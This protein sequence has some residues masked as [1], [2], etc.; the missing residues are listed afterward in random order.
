MMS[1]FAER[2]KH[3]RESR[4]I[5]REEFAK[6]F[7]LAVNT[8]AMYETSR[9]EPNLEKLNQFATFFSVSLDYL[10]GRTDDPVK[11]YKPITRE[12]LEL[13]HLTDDELYSLGPHTLDGKVLSRE[14]F[15]TLITAVR[16]R[17][18]LD[19]GD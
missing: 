11:E 13:L 18:E 10:V 19:R 5:S 8:I 17:R 16:L 15:K 14:D 2:L 3:L 1:N 6:K 12:L 7:G 9:R 4:N